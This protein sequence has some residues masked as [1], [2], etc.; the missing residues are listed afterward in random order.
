[1]NEEQDPEEFR[2]WWARYYDHPIDEEPTEEELTISEFNYECK[3]FNELERV[4]YVR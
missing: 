3:I 2:S 4:I 1:M